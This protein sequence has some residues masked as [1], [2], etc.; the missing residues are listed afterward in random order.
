M[1][2]YKF[3]NNKKQHKICHTFF[4]SN[5]LLTQPLVEQ[6]FIFFFFISVCLLVTAM[7]FTAGHC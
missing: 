4:L 7:Q 3:C 2:Q 6:L 1:Q 5:I